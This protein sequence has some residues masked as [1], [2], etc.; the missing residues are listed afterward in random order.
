MGANSGEKR[1]DHGSHQDCD[2]YK[3]LPSCPTEEMLD[4]VTKPTVQMS[5]L[6][7][8]CLLS[9]LVMVHLLTE[10]LCQTAVGDLRDLD[11]ST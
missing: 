3:C 10:G 9:I 6:V 2:P 7:G 5:M 4:A 8:L 11:R 1:A